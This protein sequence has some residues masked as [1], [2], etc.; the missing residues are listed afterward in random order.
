MNIEPAD[1]REPLRR[2]VSALEI[3]DSEMRAILKQAA[4]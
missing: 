2:L 1:A 3:T 4:R